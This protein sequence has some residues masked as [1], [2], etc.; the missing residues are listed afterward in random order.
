MHSYCI[1]TPSCREPETETPTIPTPQ[2]LAQQL[3][4]AIGQRVTILRNNDDEL[5]VVFAYDP[6]LRDV[7]R[8][9]KKECLRWDMGRWYVRLFVKINY[10]KSIL[11]QDSKVT[12]EPRVK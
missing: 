12:A 7:N 1:F 4:D 2:E 6:Q 10:D 5:W 3:A 9:G 8:W 11:W